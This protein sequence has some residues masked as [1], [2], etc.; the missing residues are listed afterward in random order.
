[1]IVLKRLSG[2]GRVHEGIVRSSVVPMSAQIAR[3]VRGRIAGGSLRVGDRLPDEETLARQFQVSRN[4]V[5]NALKELAGEGLIARRR[6]KGTFVASSPGNETSRVPAIGI[7]VWADIDFFQGLIQGA[8]QAAQARGYML[9]VA[10]SGTDEAEVLRRLCDNAIS[11]LLL[12]ATARSTHDFGPLQDAGVPVVLVDELPNLDEDYV[13]VDNFRG[14]ALAVEHLVELGHRSIAHITHDNPFDVPCQPERRR[15]FVD[16]CARLGLDEEQCP[17]LVLP[18]ITKT[19]LPKASYDRLCDLLG[20][21]G[22]P[23][24]LCCYND[25]IA[26]AACNVV[27][28]LGMAVPGDISITGFDDSDLAR[29]AP[30]PITSVSPET[31]AMGALAAELL[32]DKIEKPGRIPRQGI[33]VT[34]RLVVRDTTAPPAQEAGER[35][36]AAAR[37][38]Q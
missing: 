33:L 24:A 10:Y 27:R 23:T 29:S 6:A 2:S 7:L 30:V 4:T 36:F 25:T 28:S 37:A 15:G 17:V 35:R 1:M 32:L 14:S 12:V 21:D 38:G 18:G 11:G 9:V 13:V 34:P 19:P 5:R 26:A 8:S 31:P 20:S 16:T 3:T 22:G